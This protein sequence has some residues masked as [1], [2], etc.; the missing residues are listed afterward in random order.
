MDMTW[1]DQLLRLHLTKWASSRTKRGRPAGPFPKSWVK[2]G[3]SDFSEVGT[4]PGRFSK[5]S[6]SMS[7]VF[8]TCLADDATGTTLIRTGSSLSS[9]RE[10]AVDFSWPKQSTRHPS[11][12]YPEFDDKSQGGWA[13]WTFLFWW[14]KH[15]PTCFDIPWNF[16]KRT[17]WRRSLAR[18]LL[19]QAQWWRGRTRAWYLCCRIHPMAE[20]I[21]KSAPFSRGFKPS[22]NG[23][24]HM[25]INK[26]D[27]CLSR[28]HSYGTQYVYYYIMCMYV[29]KYIYAYIYMCVCLYFMQISIYKY[30]YMRLYVN[31]F[32]YIYIYE[33]VCACVRA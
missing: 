5:S 10:P 23:S 22:P 17:P 27:T 30:V 3:P 33:C 8:G 24:M 16:H 28:S 14:V 32:I 31:V 1:Y 19:R 26:S 13:S 18:T 15:V 20:T 4:C 25:S 29:C 2:S 11:I 6:K 7:S 9:S 12:F 21:P